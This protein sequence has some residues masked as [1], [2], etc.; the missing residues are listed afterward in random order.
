MSER[1]R[2]MP[3]ALHAAPASVLGRKPPCLP[4]SLRSR[5]DQ[6][7]VASDGQGSTFC[8]VRLTCRATRHPPLV[9]FS[10]KSFYFC[11]ACRVLYNSSVRAWSQSAACCTVILP[12]TTL[13][14]A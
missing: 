4:Q 10:R 9:T 2:G 13:L 8:V 3:T 1:S 7:Q 5:C 6:R 14:T 11:S 12:S